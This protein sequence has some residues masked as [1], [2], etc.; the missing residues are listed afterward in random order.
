MAS[1]I[2]LAAFLRSQQEASTGAEQTAAPKLGQLRQTIKQQQQQQPTCGHY[3][4]LVAAKSAQLPAREA[5]PQTACAAA[6]RDKQTHIK[7]PMN[8]FMVW[9]K[10]ERRRILKEKP[11][12]H[13]SQI[14]KILGQKWKSMSETDKQPFYEEQSRLS[15]VHMELHPDYKYQPR[16][17]RTYIID[18]RKMRLSE[19]KL[20][21]RK[22]QSSLY[23]QIIERGR[24]KPA[25]DEDVD[26][27]DDEAPQPPHEEEAD[28]PAG[29]S[30]RLDSHFGQT[31]LLD[32]EPGSSSNAEEDDEEEE[33]EEESSSTY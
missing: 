25:S 30:C 23:N 32:E 27:D 8:A 14:S 3:K 12:M 9:A 26:D 6:A 28:S 18:G 1:Q 29:A 16:P 5:A 20:L 17:K 13:N 24:R 22:R 11:F 4:L 7:R 31:T 21:L 33:E 19:Y 15:K 10:D 2:L